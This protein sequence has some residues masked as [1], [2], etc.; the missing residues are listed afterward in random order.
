[1][2]LCCCRWRYTPIIQFSIWFDFF[3]WHSDYYTTTL[4][5]YQTC[6]MKL[7]CIAPKWKIH[8]LKKWTQLKMS[9]RKQIWKNYF[10]LFEIWL[11]EVSTY[12]NS[13]V[14]KMNN[15]VPPVMERHQ[16]HLRQAARNTLT[17]SKIASSRAGQ[18]H[19]P[20]PLLLNWWVGAPP[21]QWCPGQT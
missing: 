21:P 16:I 14:E 2:I 8:P 12:L 10:I 5:S 4:A 13:Y 3:K 17:S 1:M 9:V 18:P 6:G 19:P 15:F 20:T 7:L 11:C